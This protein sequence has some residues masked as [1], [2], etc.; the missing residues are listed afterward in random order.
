MPKLIK[1]SSNEDR[2]TYYLNMGPQ[3]PS[4]HGVLR[5]RLHLRGELILSADPIIGYSHRAH[6]KMAENRSYLQFLPNTS[7]MDYLAGLIYNHGYCEAIEKIIGLEVPER[8][9]Y[10]RV[11][12]NELN[13]ISSH[14]LWFGTFLLDIGGITPFLYCFDDR[15]IILDILDRICGSRLTYCYGRFGGVSRDVDDRF[16]QEA[17]DFCK[18]MKARLPEYETLVEKN[19]IFRNRTKKVGVFSKDLVQAYAMSGPSVRS[20]GIAHDVRKDEPYGIYDRFDFKIPLG[21]NGDSFDRYKV[22]IREIEESLS[23][24]EQVTRKIPDG[25]VIAKKVPRKIAPKKGEYYFAVESPRGLL[26]IF[27]VSDGSEIPY[28]MHFRTPSLSNLAAMK[29]VLHNTMLS[30]T[31]TILG[32]IDIVLPEIDR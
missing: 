24:V 17:L 16:L 12:T 18:H 27:I 1:V 32:S 26:G 30:D 10:I 31:V 6:E 11:I 4:T 23:I 14:L 5:L 22:R 2:D 13:R 29:S 21:E 25:P 8:A 20:M 15:E 9:E 3:H 28:R 19:I 7:R